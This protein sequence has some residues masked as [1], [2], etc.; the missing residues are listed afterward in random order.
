MVSSRIWPTQC[1]TEWPESSGNGH[2]DRMS[3]VGRRVSRA[4]EQVPRAAY[5]PRGQRRR[6]AADQPL[7]I[8]DGSTCS[9]PSTVVRMLELL[10]P[11][12]GMRVLDVGS[13]SGWTAA[14]LAHLVGPEG[15]VVGVEVIARLVRSSRKALTAEGVSNAQ[16]HLATGGVLGVPD[17]APFDRIL[18]SA[19][20]A[21][22]PK[23]L[24]DQ[25]ADGGRIV[26]PVAGRMMIVDRTPDGLA[27]RV[28]GHYR[29]VPL[30][31]N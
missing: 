10:D 5:L 21:H 18:V 4:I 22:L 19:M 7:P 1:P 16:I 6:S 17:L 14:L 15:L 9:Q 30:R 20:A 29:F 12:Q 13:G 8:G 11:R 28:E 3:N 31:D 24:L 23:V 25:L 2:D 27:E 26:I